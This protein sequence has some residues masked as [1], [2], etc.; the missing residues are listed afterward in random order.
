MVV[1]AGQLLYETLEGAVEWGEGDR[2]AA[3]DHLLD[4]AENL[5]Q[6]AVMA[7]VGVGVRRFSAARPEPVIEQL[8]PV[9]LPNG[10]TRLW[11][12]DLSAYESSVV[13]DTNA[14]PNEAGQYE[15]GTQTFIRQGGR[16]FEQFFDES[17]GKWR[18]R[19]PSD[20]TAYQPI[21]GSNGRGAWRH[22]LERPWNGTV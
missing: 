10:E 9:T 12:P 8:H 22:T 6:I 14:M 18:I 13:L 2:R 19:H 7:G 1:M 4:V 15:V 17:L 11:K 5:A 16:V 3:K 20:T 21:L